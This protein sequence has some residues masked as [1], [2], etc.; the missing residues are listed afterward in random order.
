MLVNPLRN[1]TYTFSAPHL[2]ADVAQS[3]AVSPAPNT[4]TLPYILGR[5]A[6]C[7]HIP[8][9]N[10]IYREKSIPMNPLWCPAFSNHG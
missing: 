9:K 8:K 3:K 6:I 7:P 5:V 10:K 2:K 4:I 1:M